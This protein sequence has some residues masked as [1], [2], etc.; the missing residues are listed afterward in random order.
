MR[1]HENGLKKWPLRPESSVEKDAVF[2]SRT[3]PPVLEGP[4][5]FRVALVR[6]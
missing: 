5:A 3:A 6:V 4:V 2:V 1:V